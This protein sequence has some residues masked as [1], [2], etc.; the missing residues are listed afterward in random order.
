MKNPLLPLSLAVLAAAPL[1]AQITGSINRTYPTVS[2]T[3][4]TTSG[5]KMSIRY[6]AINWGQGNFMAQAKDERFCERVNGAADKQPIGSFETSKAIKLGEEDLAAG[7]YSL[8]FK[9]GDD[10]Q[11]NLVLGIGEDEYTMP[12]IL[13]EASEQRTRLTIALV[14]SADGGACS[15]HINYG[16]KGCFFEGAAA[17]STNSKGTR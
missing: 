16:N 15:Q 17:K 14:P 8:A 6:A 5:N 9:V 11:W 2:Q 12:L 1:S 3:V 10:A 13:E 7:K 4:E